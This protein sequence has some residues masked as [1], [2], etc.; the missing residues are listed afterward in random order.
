MKQRS[1][2]IAAGMTLLGVVSI[3][4]QQGTPPPGP[5]GGPGPGGQ[6]P[7]PPL[8][9][10]LDVNADGVIEA[11]EIASASTSLKKLDKNGDGKLTPDEYRPQRPP[12]PDDQGA[13]R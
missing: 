3:W 11:D 7:K 12:R 2:L 9:L 13:G 5:P 8:E 10:V 6:R 1:V 4:A